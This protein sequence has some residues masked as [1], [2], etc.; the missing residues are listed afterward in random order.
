MK[1]LKIYDSNKKY[2]Y[3]KNQLVTLLYSND[4]SMRYNFIPNNVYKINEVDFLDEYYP[5]EIKHIIDEGTHDWV[6]EDQIR[7]AEPY[8]I[9][10]NKFNL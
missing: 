1:H 3:H 5:Y 4:V 7:P 6:K 9:S 8:E 2:K 10:Q